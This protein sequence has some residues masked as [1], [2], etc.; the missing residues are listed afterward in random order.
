MTILFLSKF[1]AKYFG[2]L[3]EKGNDTDPIWVYDDTVL[4][5]KEIVN[6]HHDL[7]RGHKF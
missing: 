1:L 6:L 5:M 2:N 3:I 7:K 4:Q